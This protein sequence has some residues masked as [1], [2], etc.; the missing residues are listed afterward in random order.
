MHYLSSLYC[1]T[2]PL[3]VSGPFVAHHQEVE[4]IYVANSTCFTSETSV[5]RPGWN[6]D[7]GSKISNICHRYT[8]YLLMVGYKY[9]RNV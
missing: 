9:A 4:R 5:R 1:V 7:S 2:T 8:F 3:R 6:D